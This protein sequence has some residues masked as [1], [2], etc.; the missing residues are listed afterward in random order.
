[1][2]GTPANIVFGGAAITI[3]SDLG[4]IKDGLHLSREEEVYYVTGI[5]GIMTPPRAHRTSL[6]YTVSG[7]FLEPAIVGVFQIPL[8]WGC[9]DTAGTTGVLEVGKKADMAIEPSGLEKAVTITGIEP[10]GTDV[11]TIA[12]TK[13]TADGAGEMV[14]SD[15]EETAVP[16][17]F[18]ALYD[19][20]G[21]K[22]FT[23]TDA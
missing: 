3:G 5:E 15:Y 11:R 2:A 8:A 19:A 23:I 21:D 20:S 10:G 6:N 22:I 17:S 16:F 4:Y 7:T 1:M 18:K 9:L 14:I 13:A 12:I